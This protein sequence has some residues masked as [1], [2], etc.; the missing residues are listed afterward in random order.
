M[1]PFVE[2]NDLL[3]AFSLCHSSAD[4]KKRPF[5]V[6][7]VLITRVLHTARISNVDSVMFLIEIVEMVSF[8]LG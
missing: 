7:E 5:V 6:Y 2:Q 8:E 1:N 4:Y 3:I